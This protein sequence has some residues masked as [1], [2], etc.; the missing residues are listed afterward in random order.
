[1]EWCEDYY[2]DNYTGAPANG[3][4]WLSGGDM[5]YRVLRGGSWYSL[6]SYL[7]SAYRGWDN[8]AYRL[9]NNGFR[10]VAVVRT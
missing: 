2:H 5:K 9:V 1:M 3:S 8:P 7:R 10:V 4:A 6:A